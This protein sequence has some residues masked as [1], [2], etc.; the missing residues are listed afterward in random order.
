MQIEIT[1]VLVRVRYSF[2]T[3]I[4]SLIYSLYKFH[5]SRS[6]SYRHYFHQIDCHSLRTTFL[7]KGS[8]RSFSRAKPYCFFPIYLSDRKAVLQLGHC[9]SPSAKHFFCEQIHFSLH[10]IRNA[11]FSSSFFVLLS[12]GL[13]F[14]SVFFLFLFVFHK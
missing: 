5:I 13:S 11:S 6:N 9:F 8:N 7:E 2:C 4:Y 3:I 1:P 12:L 14:L 10:L